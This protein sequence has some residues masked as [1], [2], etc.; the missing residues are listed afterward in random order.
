MEKTDGGKEARGMAENSGDEMKSGESKLEGRRGNRRQ[1]SA[2]P[3]RGSKCLRQIGMIAS[4]HA[5]TQTALLSH[6]VKLPG[7]VCMQTPKY[8]TNR[9]PGATFLARQSE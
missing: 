4:T 9:K 1:I 2:F 7:A 3:V 5:E 6:S 8:A